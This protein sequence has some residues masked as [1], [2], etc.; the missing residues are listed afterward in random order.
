MARAPKSRPSR[1]LEEQLESQQALLDAVMNA[2]YDGICLV[3]PSGRFLEMNDAF[4]HVTG[5]KREDWVGRT[6]DQMRATPGTAR[7]SAALQVLNGSYPATTL[8]NLQGGE[9]LLVTA[10]PHFDEDGELLSIILNVRNFTQ[11]SSLKRQL[12]RHRGEEALE[13]LERSHLEGRLRNT[14]LEDFVVKSPSMVE[15]VSTAM[16]IADYDLTVLIEGETGVGKGV[17]ANLI[18]RSSRRRNKPF[19]QVNCGAIPES[20]VE[21]ELFGYESG[22]F[23]GSAPEGKEG[24]FEAAHGGTIFLDEIGELPKS[25]QAKLLQIL[26]DKMLTRVGSTSPRRLDVRVVAAT[27]RR[28]RDLARMG[29]FRADLLYRL[30]TIPLFIPPL[31]ERRE[32]LA[33]LIQKFI[34][35]CNREYGTERSLTAA[36]VEFLMGCQFEGNVRELKNK[37]VRLALTCTSAQID[38]DDVRRE[39]ERESAPPQ[40]ETPGSNGSMKA[41]LEEVERQILAETSDRCSTTYEMAEQLGIDQSSVVRKMKKYGIGKRRSG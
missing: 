16:Q 40:V 10:N 29:E 31:R 38:V 30:E 6:I 3:S 33:A 7:N 28:L 20:L 11:L 2:S 5:L 34:E 36:A 37:I 19:I 32:D 18:H 21:S 25:S 23:T 9:L 41:R 12:E 8:V 17:L 39:V 4:E 27:N 15:L 1:S 22:A 26:D 24:F 13:E 14:G 35:S